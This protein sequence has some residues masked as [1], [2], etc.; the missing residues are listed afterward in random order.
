MLDDAPGAED[1]VGRLSV[2]CD[3]GR[4]DRGSDKL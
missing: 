3:A 2:G 4:C 1:V